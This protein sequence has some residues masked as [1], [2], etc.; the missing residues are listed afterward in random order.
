MLDLNLKFDLP[1][2][3]DTKQT[4]A[5]AM[6]TNG[7]RL[8]ARIV[9]RWRVDTGRSKR[10]WRLVERGQRWTLVNGVA[11]TGNIVGGVQ[12]IDRQIDRTARETAEQLAAELPRAILNEVRENGRI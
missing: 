5:D 6:S 1:R 3:A 12:T 2:G 4:V 8:E 11:Y 10:A 9:K 7:R